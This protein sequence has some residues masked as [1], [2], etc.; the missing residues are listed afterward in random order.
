LREVEIRRPHQVWSTDITYIPMA[1]G[2]MYLVA[3]VDWYSRYVLVWRLSNTQ[4]VAFCLEALEAALA[5]ATPQIFNS[6]QKGY[7][8]PAR[9]LLHAWSTPKG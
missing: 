8:S 5:L 3:I 9:R 2:F 1:Q 7:S 6:D 4:D